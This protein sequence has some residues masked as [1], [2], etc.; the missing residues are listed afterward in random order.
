MHGEENDVD[1][2]NYGGDLVVKKGKNK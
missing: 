2:L 1:F